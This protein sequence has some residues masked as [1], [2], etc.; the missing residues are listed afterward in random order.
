MLIFFSI[1]PRSYIYLDCDAREFDKTW[2]ESTIVS[3]ED[4][5]CDKD[6][7]QSN[8]FALHRIGEV[9]G[10]FLTGYTGDR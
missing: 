6:M 4:W 1:V 10:T 8:T 2:Y 7:Y 5:V 9:V 3:Q